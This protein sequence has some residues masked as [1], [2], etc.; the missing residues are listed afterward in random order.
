[1]RP[2]GTLREWEEYQQER[3]TNKITEKNTQKP[4]P[5]SNSNFYEG[6]SFVAVAVLPRA[7]AWIFQLITRHQMAL[8]SRRNALA[9]PPRR[10]LS[11]G[12]ANGRL[13]R[14]GDGWKLMAPPSPANSAVVRR[15]GFGIRHVSY[16]LPSARLTNS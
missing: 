4:A 7:T 5:F 6:L 1:M 14:I 12:A 13:K 3:R 11:L 10:L 9:A 15:V 2:A 16:M 8:G